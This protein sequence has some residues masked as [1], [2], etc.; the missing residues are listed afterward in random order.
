MDILRSGPVDPN[1]DLWARRR[2]AE[3]RYRVGQ[4]IGQTGI[5]LAF[6]WWIH[7]FRE[8][9]EVS[10]RFMA[11]NPGD[12]AGLLGIL[13]APLLHG[14]WSHLISN[15]VPLWIL[16][17]MARYAY[18][19]ALLWALPII[20]LASGLGTWLF[21]RPSLHLG[22]SGIAHGLMFFLFV[23]GLLRRDR[24][25]IV[26]AL[27]TFFLYGSMIWTVF[28]REDGVSWEAHLYGAIGGLIA[29]VLLFRRDPVAPRAPYSWELEPD[30]DT[31]WPDD[32]DE[33]AV[34]D[35]QAQPVR[36]AERVQSLDAPS[37]WRLH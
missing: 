9:G 29:A 1:A 21:G 13:T 23:V 18:P 19:R 22:A 30:D 3:D 36:T 12:P 31:D 34:I 15:T 6:L 8:V 35:G 16:G 4:A 24:L 20:W 26:V 32:D 14:S 7:L 28:P 37:R 27:I 11:I 5:A 2:A 25:A 10:W 33:G 17:S